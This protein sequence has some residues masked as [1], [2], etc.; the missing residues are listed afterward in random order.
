MLKR[1][2]FVRFDVVFLVLGEAVEEDYPPLGSVSHQH[3]ITARP[4]MPRARDPLL[5]ETTA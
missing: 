4:S 2:Q 1:C 5:N 3:P